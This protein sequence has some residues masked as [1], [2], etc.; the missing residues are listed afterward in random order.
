MA[1]RKWFSP[2][3]AP[4]YFFAAAIAAGA[5]ALR[6]QPCLAQAPLSWVD[7]VF[8]ATSAV[9]VTGLVVVDT[10]SYFTATGQSVIMGLIQLGGLGI[11]T[12]TSLVLYLWRRRTSLMDRMAV[13]QNLLHDPGF[14]LGRFLIQVV[15]GVLCMELIGAMAIFL[16]APDGFGPFSACFHAVSAFCNAGFSLH[17]TS[18]MAWKADPWLNLV[19]M[20]LII[21]GGLGFSVLLEI[22][23]LLTRLRQRRDPAHFN[24]HRLS[25]HARI[26]LV[27]SAGLILGGAAVILGAEYMLAPGQF[28]PAEEILASLFQSV[29]CRTAGFNTLDIGNMTNISLLVMIFLMLVGGS[30]GSCAGGVKTTTLRTLTAFS[31]SRLKGRQQTVVSGYAVNRETLNKALS[32]A[33]FAFVIICGATLILSVTEV[34]AVPHGQTRGAFLDILFEVVSAFGTV[35]LSTGLTAKLTTLGKIVITAVMFIG[36]LGPIMFLSAIREFHTE[37]RFSWP[38]NTLLIG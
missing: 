20:A 2:F 1:T 3:T 24:K 16:A 21:L 7:A 37:E 32:L 19:F 33:M 26:V 4:I 8:T 34:G 28:S 5:L 17:A 12:Y 18:L 35:G 9:C 22:F 38:E 14:H 29:T 10:G 31:L 6:L 30:P 15:A 25:W 36:R 13:G 27:T 11:M 23:E